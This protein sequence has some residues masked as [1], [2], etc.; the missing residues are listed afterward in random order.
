MLNKTELQEFA[1]ERFD[2]HTDT[3]YELLE[4]LHEEGTADLLILQRALVDNPLLAEELRDKL[5]EAYDANPDAP[6]AYDAYYGQD[7]GVFSDH[8]GLEYIKREDAR[9]QDIILLD[10]ATDL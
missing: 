7:S 3:W 10:A 4:D 6:T 8:N 9:P 2:E 1:N 5:R